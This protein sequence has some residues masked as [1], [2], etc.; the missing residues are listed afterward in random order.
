MSWFGRSST[1]LPHPWV[2]RCLKRM[3]DEG[4]DGERYVGHKEGE[5]DLL[6]HI[7]LRS[8]CSVIGWMTS[9]LTS[10]AAFIAFVIV[11]SIGIHFLYIP[12]LL[13]SR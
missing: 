4:E 10:C 2:T 12:T 11:A 6:R 1:L 5:A 13:L 7:A 3:C 9:P 8:W